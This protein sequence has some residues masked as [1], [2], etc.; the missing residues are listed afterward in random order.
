MQNHREFRQGENSFVQL[1]VNS[2]LLMVEFMVSGEK[3][4]EGGWLT[5]IWFDFIDKLV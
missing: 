2:S 3:E 1:L 5:E 4:G